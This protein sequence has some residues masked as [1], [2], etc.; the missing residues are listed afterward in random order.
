MI[1]AFTLVG[2]IFGIMAGIT[3]LFAGYPWYLALAVWSGIG[4]LATLAAALLP[5]PA[6]P[7]AR[8]ACLGEAHNG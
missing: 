5:S 8:P 7:A 4:A 6:A 1:V 2:S 3:A